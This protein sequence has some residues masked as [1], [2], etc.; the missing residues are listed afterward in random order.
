[1]TW[2]NTYGP[3]LLLIGGAVHAIPMLND[4]LWT[5]GNGYIQMVVGIISVV[6]ALFMI[7]G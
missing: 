1:M 5:L 4:W 3:W 7:K 2:Y 6:A